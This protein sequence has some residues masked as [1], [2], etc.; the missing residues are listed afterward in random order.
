MKKSVSCLV[1]LLS[2]LV[3]V[4]CNARPTLHIV[5]W[6]DYMDPDLIA[7]FEAEYHCKVNEKI[8]TS[9]EAIASVLEASASPYDLAVPSEYMVQK[10]IDLGL[11]SPIDFSRLE[12]WENVTVFPELEALYTPMG[13][14]DYVVPYAWGTIGILYNTQNHPE[15]GTLIAEEGWGAL[16]D[17]TQQYNVGMY[18]SSRDAVAAAL[19]YLGYSVNSEDVG[20]LALAEQALISGRFSWG[21]DLLRTSV[22]SGNLDMAL[23]YSGDFLSEYYLA[24]A[25]GI[26]IGFDYGVPEA[27]TN[28][29][30][31]AF[32]LCSSSKNADLAYKF[33]DFFLQADHALPNYDYIGY[34]PC[35]TEY[36]QTMVTD[37]GY[38]LPVFDPYPQAAVRQMYVYG[39]DTRSQRVTQ[40]LANAKDED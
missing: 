23:V 40:I 16:F 33:I 2:I 28:V 13:I 27:G 29:W 22:I 25:D 5:N 34:A 9:N 26:T 39:S 11:V 4:G 6:G 14:G 37:Y 36:F 12:H 18:D 24:E 30:M 7:Q 10:L 38:D 35:Y 21:E 32:V 8:A 20:Q 15:I 3:L 31:D 17:H 19:L 1:L